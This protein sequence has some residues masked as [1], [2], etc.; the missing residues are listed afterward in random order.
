MAGTYRSRP[1]PD[2][3]Q[4]GAG[5]RVVE[6]SAACRVGKPAGTR[7]L[8]VLGGLVSAAFCV[9]LL[10]RPGIGAITMALLFGLFNLVY[11]SRAVVQGI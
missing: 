4:L 7:G 2:R 11:G 10:A 8:L 9:A 3:G 6:I 1:S 5:R